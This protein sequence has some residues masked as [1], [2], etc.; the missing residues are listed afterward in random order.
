M[1]D[2]LEFI[3]G[4]I[5]LL[6]SWRFYVC[7][8]LALALVGLIYFLIPDR[9]VCLGLSIP[10]VVIGMGSGIYWQRRNRRS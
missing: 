1:W 10:V 5:D 8:L 3:C 7:L 6:A 4:I 2:I 9:G